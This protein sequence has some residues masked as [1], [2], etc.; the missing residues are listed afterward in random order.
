VEYFEQ[1]KKEVGMDKHWTEM[2]K[3]PWP[4]NFDD[5][6]KLAFEEQM[7]D[8]VWDAAKRAMV[9]PAANSLLEIGNEH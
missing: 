6:N 3:R 4:L 1:M 8:T 5:D 7:K 9:P 2:T